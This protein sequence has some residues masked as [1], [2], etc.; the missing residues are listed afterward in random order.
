M[1]RAGRSA[2]R[3]GRDVRRSERTSPP[4]AAQSVGGPL[5]LGRSAV[6]AARPPSAATSGTADESTP[7]GPMN[8]SRRIPGGSGRSGS[9]RDGI[10]HGIRHKDRGEVQP[11]PGSGVRRRTDRRQ[12]GASS[13]AGPR[14]TRAGPRTAGPGTGSPGPGARG[15]ALPQPHARTSRMSA[16]SARPPPYGYAP[17][18]RRRAA[19]VRAVRGRAPY[20]RTD[21]PATGTARTGTGRPRPSPP[22]AACRA[23]PRLRAE[24]L[25]CRSPARGPLLR[26]RA[27]ARA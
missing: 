21:A 20:G 18:P 13:R 14:T 8:P 1:F 26:L 6:R 4:A 7:L 19:S 27:E 22:T 5:S 15:R 2:T 10:R 12:A 9:V 24:P 16:S 23:L 25:G 3:A 17:G 11:R